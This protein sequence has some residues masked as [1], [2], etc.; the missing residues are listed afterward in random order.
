MKK[1]YNYLYHIILALLLVNFSAEAQLNYSNGKISLKNDVLQ[2]GY[3]DPISEV[4]QSMDV[5]SDITLTLFGNP[6]PSPY[7]YDVRTKPLLIVDLEYFPKDQDFYAVGSVYTAIPR[8]FTVEFN[9]EYD[10]YDDANTF[11]TNTLK[12]HPGSPKVFSLKLTENRTSETP[13]SNH[14][15]IVVFCC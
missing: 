5:P 2:F 12:E 6:A 3:I 13:F 11:Q 7:C 10:Y 9:I 1:K 15:Q 14:Q 8:E 4:S